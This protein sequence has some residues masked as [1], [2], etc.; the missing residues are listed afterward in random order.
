MFRRSGRRF[1]EKNMRQIKTA[2]RS[3]DGTHNRITQERD[4]NSDITMRRRDALKVIGAGLLA[5]L[6]LGAGAKAQTYAAGPAN[7]T[8]TTQG[9]KPASVHPFSP[10]AIA[11]SG[12][13]GAGGIHQGKRNDCVFEASAAAVATTPRGRIAISR[14]ITQDPDDGYVVTFPGEPQAHITVTP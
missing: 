8:A 5:N 2:P 4:M 9:T 3:G 7:G 13:S 10:E 6:L 12:Q 1:A 11:N 14:M